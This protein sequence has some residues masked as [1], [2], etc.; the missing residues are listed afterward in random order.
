MRVLKQGM[1]QA[2]THAA[3]ARV[4]AAVEQ[5]LDDVQARGDAAVRELSER[6]DKWS[7]ESFRLSQTQIE[8]LV[9]SLPEQVIAD[10]QFA[11][12]QVRNFAQKQRDALRDIEV[13]TLP[14]VCLGYKTSRSKS[15]AASMRLGAY[16]GMAC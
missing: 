14:G 4:R 7:P 11:Q 12:A 15:L 1:S 16:R 13:E 3:D 2:E 5:I 9:A 6:F 10:L 8:A